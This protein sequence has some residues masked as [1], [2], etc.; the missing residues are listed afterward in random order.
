MVKLVNK[1]SRVER[2]YLLLYPSAVGAI[3]AKNVCGVGFFLNS[4]E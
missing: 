2:H 4:S 3:V 1:Q